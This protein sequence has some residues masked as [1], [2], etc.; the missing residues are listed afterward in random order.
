DF[1]L[2][3]FCLRAP[4]IFPISFLGKRQAPLPANAH[5]RGGET[6]T[7]QTLQRNQVAAQRGISSCHQRSEREPPQTRLRFGSQDASAATAFTTAPRGEYQLKGN[8]RF[9]Q[10]EAE[11]IT[12]TK[13]F[14]SPRADFLKRDSGGTDVRL[15]ERV[16]GLRR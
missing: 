4:D 15:C 6:D 5:R 1:V 2:L 3:G 10:R 8:R 11:N 16:T 9:T 12:S 13:L 14:L 7:R